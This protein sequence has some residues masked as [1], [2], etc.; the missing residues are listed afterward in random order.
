MN[1]KNFRTLYYYIT[2][3]VITVLFIVAGLYLIGKNENG[4]INNENGTKDSNQQEEKIT[5]NNIPG[6]Q[7]SPDQ[8]LF[9]KAVNE[10]ENKNYQIAIKNLR[11]AIILNPGITSYYSLKSEA[12]ITTSQIEEA[13]KTLEAGLK[14]DPSS[15]ILNSKLDIL[16]KE[17]FYPADEEATR[18]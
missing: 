8:E 7:L 18:G 14:I 4:G 12:E 3:L 15:E 17:H 6:G 13:K 5:P 16:N 10:F 2:L 9:V 11:Q 1:G